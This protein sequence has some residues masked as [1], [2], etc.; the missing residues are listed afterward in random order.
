[1]DFIMLII[2]WVNYYVPLL[3]LIFLA[4]YFLVIRKKQI[5]KVAGLLAEIRD[6][7]KKK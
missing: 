6:L 1:M 4:V 7:L 2:S 5:E 3:I